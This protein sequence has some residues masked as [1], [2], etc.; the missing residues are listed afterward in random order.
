MASSIASS[1]ALVRC[2][3]ILFDMDGILISSLGSVERS[4]TKWAGIRGVDPAFALTMIHGR[5]AI[6][7]VA[8]LRPDLDNAEQC[9]G[10]RVVHRPRRRV[11]V[12]VL[13]YDDPQSAAD[14]YREREHLAQG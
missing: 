5:R 8:L 13:R 2:K 10:F 12:H 6:E 11:V 7:S 3:G 4:W 1:P 14:E 9:I